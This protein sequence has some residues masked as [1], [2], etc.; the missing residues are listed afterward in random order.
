MENL[1]RHFGLAV[2]VSELGHVFCC[3]LP[4]IFTVLSFAANIGLIGMAPSWMLALHAKIHHYEVPIIIFSGVILALGWFA[5]SMSNK[6]DCHDTGCGH[7]PCT[8]E[9]D[10][11]GKIMIVAT[12]LF[13][14]NLLIYTVVHKNVFHLDMFSPVHAVHDDI[15]AREGHG[16]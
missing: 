15:R 5:H 12:A 6:V 16:Q 10:R 2:L 7:P 8:P 14:T 4:T 1:R 9:K 13:I 11:N 3:V